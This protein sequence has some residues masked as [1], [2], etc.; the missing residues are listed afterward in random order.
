MLQLVELLAVLSGATFGIL[1]ASR[2]RLDF[3]GDYSV[4]FITAFGGGTL[5]DLFLDRTPL[6]WIRE[7]HYPLIVFGL[8]ILGSLHGPFG[9][10]KLEKFLHVPDALGLGL[11]SI[12]GTT[13]ALNEGVPWF[14]A[15]LFG[16]ITGTFGGVSGDVICNEIPSLFRQSPLCA[17]CAF[18]G[19][20]IYILGTTMPIDNGVLMLIAAGGV[21]VM[22]LLALRFN[23][24]LPTVG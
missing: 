8:A 9:G 10:R 16:V 6:F 20:W 5:R 2:K 17:T 1:L 21:V 3:V 4:A 18:V 22:R 14:V 11:F 15:S 7:A 23:W 24:E 12:V 19:S 13:V